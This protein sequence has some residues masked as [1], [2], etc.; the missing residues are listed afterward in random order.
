[1][2]IAFSSILRLGDLSK[3]YNLDV[4]RMNKIRL[5]VAQFFLYCIDAI[6]SVIRTAF[7][8]RSP[9]VF[10]SSVAF[11]EST[12]RLLVRAVWREQ[13]SRSEVQLARARVAAARELGDE[14]RTGSQTPA[15]D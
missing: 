7:T 15:V 6:L 3:M 2:A 13:Q 11:E 10:V 8:D 1:M 12:E 5:A 4:H 9:K 14:G